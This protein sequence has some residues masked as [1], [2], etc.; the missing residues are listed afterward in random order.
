MNKC[1][2]SFGPECSF[3]EVGEGL[4]SILI[5]KTVSTVLVTLTETIESLGHIS[6]IDI[7]VNKFC[8]EVIF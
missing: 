1:F 4:F 3:L 2:T 5:W 7:R 6:V 8:L